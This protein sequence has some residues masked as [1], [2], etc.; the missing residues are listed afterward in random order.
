MTRFSLYRHRPPPLAE[1]LGELGALVLWTDTGRSP[2][3][4]DTVVKQPTTHYSS[5]PE[6]TFQNKKLN[7]LKYV[8]VVAVAKVTISPNKHN[9]VVF[10]EYIPVNSRGTADLP[11]VICGVVTFF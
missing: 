4:K 3:R 6:R 1:I 11:S 7:A 5:H 2:D 9:F 8:R 10:S